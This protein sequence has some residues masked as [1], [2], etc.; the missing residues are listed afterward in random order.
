MVRQDILGGLRV[1]LSKGK[2]LE[3]SMQAFYNAGYPK[4]EIEEAARALN[5]Q[6]FSQPKPILPPPMPIQ[7]IPKPQPKPMA[8]FQPPIKPRQESNIQNVPQPR[9]V[10]KQ[11]AYRPL[12]PPP[13]AKPVISS[14][15]H[16]P[17]GID[18][19]TIILVVILLVLLGVLAAIFFY[20][21]QLVSFLNQYLE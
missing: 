6:Q 20:K 10:M 16:K 7:P 2:N 13:V 4:E 3:E 17:S 19:I 11:P 5:D 21:D 18:P 9:P 1:A 14:Y 8:E 12:T 15:D